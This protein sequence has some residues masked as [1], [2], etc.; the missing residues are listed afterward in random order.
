[1]ENNIFE[2]LNMLMKGQAAPQQPTNNYYPNEAYSASSSP[3]N[4][5]MQNSNLMPML[6]SLMS[7]NN[8]LGKIM[9]DN[10]LNSQTKK[11]SPKNDEQEKV[12]PSDDIII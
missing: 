6:M 12:M 5:F 2:L 10:G 4:T 3:N 9:G 7:G 11:S 1:M 8:P